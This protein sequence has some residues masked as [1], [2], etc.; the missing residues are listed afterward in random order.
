MSCTTIVT[1]GKSCGNNLGGIKKAWFMDQDDFEALGGTN[2]VLAGKITAS[3]IV[4]PSPSPFV[5]MYFKRNAAS[6]VGSPQVDFGSGSTVYNYTLSMMFQKREA[7][8]SHALNIM[9]EGQ[10]YLV[11]VILDSNGKY[12]F[13]ENLQLNGG[14][15]TTGTARTEGS[16]YDVTMLG[17]MDH[18]CY[19]IVDTVALSW[20]D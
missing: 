2:T 4:P 18:R 16:K 7:A 14:D 6:L 8:K 3:T 20:I 15:E 10:R 5:N 1:I 17:E 12:W 9:G 19:E 11:A 13:V